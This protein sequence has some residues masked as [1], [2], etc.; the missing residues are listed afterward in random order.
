MRKIEKGGS[1]VVSQQDPTGG[2]HLQDTAVT[3]VAL[4]LCCEP[5]FIGTSLDASAVD[6]ANFY[7]GV[8]LG[9]WE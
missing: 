7:G 3:I 9:L 5:K 1:V 8:V 2:S 4:F 6:I